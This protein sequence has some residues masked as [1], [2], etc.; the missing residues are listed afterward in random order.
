MGALFT[1]R[2]DLGQL[3][4]SSETCK[5]FFLRRGAQELKVQQLLQCD[6]FRFTH[7]WM[8]NGRLARLLFWDIVAPFVGVFVATALAR[9][10]FIAFKMEIIKASLIQIDTGSWGEVLALSLR[11]LNRVHA[12][13]KDCGGAHSFGAYGCIGLP[14]SQS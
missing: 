6:F 14:L 8:E 7:T 13:Q 9:E 3:S 5:N 1:T 2:R 4:L 12:L 10:F 11:C